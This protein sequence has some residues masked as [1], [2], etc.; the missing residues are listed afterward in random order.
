MTYTKEINDLGIRLFIGD[1]VTESEERLISIEKEM[2]EKY[3][4]DQ[5]LD[6]FRR[7]NKDNMLDFLRFV[8]SNIK[9]E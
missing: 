3:G 6:L 8:D 2:E 4:K 7:Y 5:M 1:R 9:S